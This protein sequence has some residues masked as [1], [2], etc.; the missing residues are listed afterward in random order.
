MFVRS[1]HPVTGPTW[2]GSPIAESVRSQR[3]A[4]RF[5]TDRIDDWNRYQLSDVAKATTSDPIVEKRAK[6]LW[7]QFPCRP[8]KKFGD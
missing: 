1:V 5:R 6:S 2:D 8:K 3:R 7:N 4:R